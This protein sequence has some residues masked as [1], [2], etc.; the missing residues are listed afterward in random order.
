VREYERV[1]AHSRRF[2]VAPGHELPDAETIIEVAA[3]YTV[4]EKRDQAGTVAEASD[5]R[6]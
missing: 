5:P 1:R 6:D 3:G 2:V 4:V